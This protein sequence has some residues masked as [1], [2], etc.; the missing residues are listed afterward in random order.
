M[1]LLR[2]R[3]EVRGW[4]KRKKRDKARC[5][6]L[7][8]IGREDTSRRGIVAFCVRVDTRAC[9]MKGTGGTHAPKPEAMFASGCAVRGTVEDRSS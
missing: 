3:E 1:P 9:F 5:G 4:E 2:D 8:S 7:V 6:Q